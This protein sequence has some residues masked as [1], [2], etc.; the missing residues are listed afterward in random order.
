VPCSYLGTRGH[1]ACLAYIHGMAA[2]RVTPEVTESVVVTGRSDITPILRRGDPTFD[3]A[4]EC[5]GKSG[6]NYEPMSWDTEV[7]TAMTP[8]S[9]AQR[10][11]VLAFSWMG[12]ATYGHRARSALTAGISYNTAHKWMASEP[13]PAAIKTIHDQAFNRMGIDA[14]WVLREHLRLYEEADAITNALNRIRTQSAILEQIANH[15][16]VGAKAAE[17]VDVQHT[18]SFDAVNDGR[19]RVLASRRED[20]GSDSTQ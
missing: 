8:L 11:F 6:E 16:A 2:R 19:A 12:S 3:A 14:E 20:Q 4:V 5:F 10:A 18:V 1:S 7:I 9:S 13:V 17:K 15:K